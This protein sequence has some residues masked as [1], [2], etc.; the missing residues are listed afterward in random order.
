MIIDININIDF[1]NSRNESGVFL[2]LIRID[3]HMV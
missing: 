2:F 3:L 1:K